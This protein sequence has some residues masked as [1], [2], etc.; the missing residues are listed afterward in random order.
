MKMFGNLSTDGAEAS[1]DRL[2][3]GGVLD[4]NAYD[5]IVK[6]AY[7]GKSSGGAHSV[8]VHIDFGGHEYR[9]TFYVTNKA[10]DVFYVD[11]NDKTK[12]RLLPGFESVDEL[13]LVTTG[14]SLTEQVTEEKVVKLY[15]FEEKREVPTNV[16]VLVDLIGKPVTVGILRQTVDKTQKDNAGNYVP[17]GETRDENV[18]DK[19]FHAETKRTVT[20]FRENIEEAVFYPK[21][22]EKNK[23]KTRNRAKGAEGKTGAPGRMAP[24]A[25]TAS[26]PKTS[27]FGPK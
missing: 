7:A 22:V 17:T 21:W 19:F 1:G 26:Q 27:L 4:T 13:C 2:G 24:A 9:E 6:L 12:R 8:T 11:K 15:D 18:A 10:G 3:G 23:G 14:Q 16:P 5:G 20:E 25:N